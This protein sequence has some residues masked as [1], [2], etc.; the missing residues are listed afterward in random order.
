METNYKL[1]IELLGDTQTIMN[2]FNM[3]LA[4]DEFNYLMG[5][6]EEVLESLLDDVRG[7]ESKFV[8]LQSEI[9][10]AVEKP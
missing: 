4:D 2:R 8:T 7:I 6:S 1:R 3:T 9:Q 10:R 5:R